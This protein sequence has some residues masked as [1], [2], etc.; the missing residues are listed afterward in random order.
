MSASGADAERAV[1][2][3]RD[4]VVAGFGELEAEPA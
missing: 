1:R 4:L 3:V 2:T